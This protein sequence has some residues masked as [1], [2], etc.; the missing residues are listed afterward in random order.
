MPGFVS[1]CLG[2]SG[3]TNLVNIAERAYPEGSLNGYQTRPRRRRVYRDH[4]QDAHDIS[5]KKRFPIVFPR[6]R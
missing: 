5:L 1:Y 4:E 3:A 2:V 6:M